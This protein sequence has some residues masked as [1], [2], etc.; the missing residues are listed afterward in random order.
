MQSSDVWIW[1]I[2]SCKTVPTHSGTAELVSPVTSLNWN[3][4]SCHTKV[5]RRALRL[6]PRNSALQM[7][8]FNIFYVAIISCLCHSGIL[9]L[10]L[11]ILG[12][13]CTLSC[14]PC[15]T[16]QQIRPAIGGH[17]MFYIDMVYR[18]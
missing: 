12:L 13:K 5:I 14:R 15:N 17:L 10:V 2:V 1:C 7:S 11:Y 3:V 16:L 6:L 4:S 18:L 8:C 9:S